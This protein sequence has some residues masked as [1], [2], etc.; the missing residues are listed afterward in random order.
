M[1]FSTLGANPA[2]LLAH[3]GFRGRDRLHRGHV[4][5]GR[6][7]VRQ[8]RRA[9]GKNT[10]ECD[11][12]RSSNLSSLLSLQPVTP[13]AGTPG[14]A[15]VAADAGGG[16]GGGAAGGGQSQGSPIMM[17]LPFLIMIP[18]FFLMSRRQKKEQEARAKLKKGDQVVTQSGIIG[19]LIESDDRIA[20]VKIAPGTTVRV[21]VSALGPLETEK[22]K[23][24]TSKDLK[25]LKE[26]KATAA[27]SSK[28]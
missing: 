10:K 13:K 1:T 16:S 12:M 6:S 9:V 17:F 20:K 2:P 8:G 22:A 18:F 11:T 19:E 25:D 4:A 27:E 3:L 26:A 15:G 7:D 23:G 5:R 14:V 21:L 24:D 28:K